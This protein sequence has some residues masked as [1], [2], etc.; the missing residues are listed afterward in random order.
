MNVCILLNC[1]YDLI[2]HY[3]VWLIDW[4]S[5]LFG[6]PVFSATGG[7]KYSESA[8]ERH[9]PRCADIINKPTR[10]NAHQG[11]Y[12]SS[13]SFSNSNTGSILH[14]IKN[15]STTGGTRSTTRNSRTASPSEPL[16][17]PTGRIYNC[18]YC[19]DKFPS[20]RLDIHMAGCG[21]VHAVAKT[22]QLLRTRGR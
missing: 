18:K 9:I 12:R 16:P 13:G 22:T 5:S 19:G 1:F 21:A 8:A 7:R 3:C 14:D 17:A 11:R 20:T 15:Y 6:F 2:F 10:L 4:P